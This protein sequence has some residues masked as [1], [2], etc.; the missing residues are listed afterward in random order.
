MN[1]QPFDSAKSIDAP[2]GNQA[3]RS[4][5]ISTDAPIDVEVY[6][7]EC[8]CGSIENHWNR[9]RNSNP[10]FKSPFFDIK[11]TQAVGRVRDDVRIAI[12]L[13]LGEVVGFLP[14]QENKPGHAVPVGGLLNDWHAI[15][16]TQSSEVLQQI[17]KA[18]KLNSFKFHA[19][20]AEED[21]LEK[22]YFRE[23][24]SHYL[25]LS[26]GWEAYQKWVFKNSSAV[27]RQGQK[28][29]GLARKFGEIRFEFESEDANQLER[30][31][32]LK[33]AK[34]QRSNTFDILGVRWASNLL[35]ELH[36]IRDSNFRGVLSVL[37]AGDHMVGAHFGMLTEETL[38][39]WFPV[40]DPAFHK[41]SLIHI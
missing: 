3:S 22:Y 8:L 25:D 32:E 37:W 5:V 13:S 6:G 20:N 7:P 4:K 29:R 23:F 2:F 35:R 12:V 21:G 31:I 14:F 30:L 41:L 17:L 18:A 40:Y 9:I 19:I 39:Y 26:D 10:V 1:T 28:T 34:Y 36:Q 38:H 16:G 27:K 24:K 15:M 33:R 11:F